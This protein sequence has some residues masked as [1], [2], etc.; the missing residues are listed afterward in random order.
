MHA[1]AVDAWITVDVNA[2]I[3]L[4]CSFHNYFSVVFNQ[5][6]CQLDFIGFS[7]FFCSHFTVQYDICL[8]A[9]RTF[10]V[11]FFVFS[12]GIKFFVFYRA[13]ASGDEYMSWHLA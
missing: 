8:V 12:N 4:S 5:D 2:H 1:F 6:R 7:F 11:S 10:S 13:D 9:M 3:A